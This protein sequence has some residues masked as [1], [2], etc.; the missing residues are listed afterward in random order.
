MASEQARKR[1]QNRRKILRSLHFDGPQQR[2]QLS[3]RGIRKS[4]TTT[5]VAELI[6]KGLVIEETPGSIR[7]R[8]QLNP[9]FNT[10]AASIRRNQIHFA[11]VSLDGRI[12]K[13]WQQA[14]PDNTSPELLL[15]LL[16]NGLKGHP[17]SPMG[18]GVCLPGIIDPAA[19]HL[20]RAI[21]PGSWRNINLKQRLE[22]SLGLNVIVDNDVRAQLWSTAWFD[23]LLLKA[24]NMLYL[25]LLDGIACAMIVHSRRLIGGHFAAGEIGHINAGGL[26]RICSCGKLDCLETYCSTPIIL[27]EISNAMGRPIH[28]LQEVAELDDPDA[29]AILDRVA[30]QLARAVAGLAAAMDSELLIV[31]SG[32]RSF[33]EKICPLLEEHLSSELIGLD[34]ANILVA[35]SSDLTTLKGVAGLVIEQAFDQDISSWPD[36]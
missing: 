4:S 23:R 7:S 33:T 28:D 6:E 14:L 24:E 31:G 36:I 16:T 30:K 27:K 25:G 17:C 26:G 2:G 20:H 19:G 9:N 1:T 29:R 34:A 13:R 32:H 15:E 10:L 12:L 11:S 5:I 35:E 3:A 22:E 21:Y 8:I 18:V